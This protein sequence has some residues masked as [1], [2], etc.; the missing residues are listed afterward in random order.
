MSDTRQELLDAGFEEAC[1][2]DGIPRMLPRKVAI[3]GRSV[4]LCKDQG[5][6][7]AVDE[8]CPHKHKSMAYGVVHQGKITCPHHQY[9]F[10]LGTGRCKR[11]RCAPVMVYAVEVVDGSVFVKVD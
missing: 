1:S 9:D 10:E 6:V 3:G 4:L 11:R 2:V 7:Y 8:I 5:E